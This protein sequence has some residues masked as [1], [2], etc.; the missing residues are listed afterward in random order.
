MIES[1]ARLK[2]TIDEAR[3]RLLSISERAASDK[4]FPDKWSLKEVLGHLCD[5]ATNNRQRIVRMQGKADIGTFV[6][7]Q[8]VWVTSQHYQSEPWEQLVEFWYL[9]NA[10]LAHIIAH[11]DRGAL[12]HLCDMGYAKPATLK[13]VIE[14]YIRHVDH[15]LGQIFTDAGPMEREIW[16]PRSPT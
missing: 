6:Y 13:F 8:K 7:D 12:G 4:P 10:H 9:Y 11:V 5:S 3:P 1:S 15:H 14:D 16:V 2:Q